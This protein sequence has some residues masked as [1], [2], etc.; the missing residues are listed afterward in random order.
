[1]DDLIGLCGLVIVRGAQ[2]GEIWY[3]V[4]PDFRGRRVATQAVNGLLQVGFVEFALHRIWAT[5]LPENPASSRV[6]ENV[7]MRKEG[8]LSK[9]LMIHGEWKS[10]LLYAMLAEEWELRRSDPLRTF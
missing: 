7:G 3:L 9:N 2:E 10:S 5:C 8:F 6:L 4:N 1:M